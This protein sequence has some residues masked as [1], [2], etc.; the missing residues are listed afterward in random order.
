MPKQRNKVISFKADSELLEKIDELSKHFDWTR[1]DVIRKAISAL[2]AEYLEADER[3][4]DI[5]T[6]S[7][8][9]S[10]IHAAL[11]RHKEMVPEL[12]KALNEMDIMFI[13]KSTFIEEF[14]NALRDQLGEHKK[15]KDENAENENDK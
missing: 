5:K 10:K 15:E 7:N 1:S 9:L 3:Y 4:K 12:Q 2:H 11:E 6:M 8:D 13:R 14:V